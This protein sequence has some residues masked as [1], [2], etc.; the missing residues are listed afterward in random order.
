MARID[1]LASALAAIDTIVEQGEGSPRHRDESHFQRFTDMKEEYERLSAINP[2]FQPAWPAAESP[3]MRRPPS[4]EGKTFVEN[5]KTARVLDFANAVYGL[6]LRCLVQVF[7][8]PLTVGRENQRRF[9]DAA[10]ELMHMLARLG[11]VLTKLPAGDPSDGLNAGMTFTMLRSLS[12][13][14]GHS[15]GTTLVLERLEELQ[16]SLPSIIQVAPELSA[17]SDPLSRL[18]RAFA[19]HE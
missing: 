15:V 14:L 2:D 16:G 17:M 13:L 19:H 5:P 12:P 1:D 6:L 8:S 7:E 11:T 4:P 18:Q 3:V 9:M 10:I